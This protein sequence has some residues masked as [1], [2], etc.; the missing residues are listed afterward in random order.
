MA[1]YLCN[2][3]YSRI[4]RHLKMQHKVA[5]TCIK[6]RNLKEYALMIS[7]LPLP[8]DINK[9]MKHIND[10]SYNDKDMPKETYS[11]LE[12]CFRLYKTNKGM[13]PFL[14]IAKHKTIKN[15]K[16]KLKEK[17]KNEKEK[18]CTTD[19]NPVCNPTNLG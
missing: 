19:N 7:S 18:S 11:I 16:R 10:Y 1:C 15:V 17:P 6:P 2:K 4:Q 3:S 9:Y 5:D 8:K 12:K 13:K 14:S